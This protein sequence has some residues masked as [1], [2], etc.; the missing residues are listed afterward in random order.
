MKKNNLKKYKGN[1]PLAKEYKLNADA[2]LTCYVSCNSPKICWILGYP[3]VMSYKYVG[4]FTFNVMQ[5]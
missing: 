5:C 3:R 1:N 2:Q 4:V